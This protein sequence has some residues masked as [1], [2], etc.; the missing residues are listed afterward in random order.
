MLIFL[1]F[2]IWILILMLLRKL[3]IYFFTFL[4]GSVGLFVF[5]MIAGMDSGEK[6]L[7][8]AV[9]YCMQ[10]IGNY[11]YL[12]TA[13]PEYSVITSYH[14][15]EA[16]SFFVDYECSGFIEMLV[17]ISLLMFYPMYGLKGKALYLLIG[18]VY[19]FTANVIRVFVIC[20]IIRF[21]G[22][23]LFFLS[24]TVIARVLFFM[25]MVALYYIVFTRPHVLRQKVGSLT[26]GS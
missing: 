24:H 6:Y 19:I 7:E 4:L 18:M 22:I 16:V 1:L 11:T 12:F 15:L 8:Y 2:I 9:T 5:M 20:T 21:F 14:D 13:Y 10:L 17:Y 23:Q 25:L 3:K 26:Y